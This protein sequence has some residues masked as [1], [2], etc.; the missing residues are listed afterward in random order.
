M[1]LATPILMALAQL[2]AAPSYSQVT[3]A[4]P[5]SP[6][7]STQTSAAEDGTNRNSPANPTSA[8]ATAAAANP[9]ATPV[10]PPPS[11]AEKAQEHLLRSQGYK[12][13][14]VDGKEM[15]CRREAPLGSRLMSRVH[16]VTVQE[17]ELMSKEGRETAEHIQRSMTGCIVPVRGPANCGN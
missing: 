12:L 3:P 14:M 5:A 6:D 7:A 16:C 11:S 9:A 8:P 13:A 17:A 1:K 15:F 10:K 2:V 4:S